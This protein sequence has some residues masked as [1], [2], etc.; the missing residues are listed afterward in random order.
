MSKL[1]LEEL[2]KRHAKIVFAGVESSF[3]DGIFEARFDF[4]LD[5]DIEFHPSLRLPLRFNLRGGLG[6]GGFHRTKGGARVK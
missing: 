4:R 6:V 5:P 1:S 2:R 3:T